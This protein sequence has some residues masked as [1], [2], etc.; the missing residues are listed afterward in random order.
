MSINPSPGHP[1]PAEAV[2]TV[3]AATAAEPGFAIDAK[4]GRYAITVKWR[5]LLGIAPLEARVRPST[6]LISPPYL[7]HISPVSPLYLPCI[8]PIR[9][10]L[11]S[12]H[13]AEP[14]QR[15]GP[16]RGAAPTGAELGGRRQEG[17]RSL[18]RTLTRTLTLTLT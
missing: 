10:A 16:P 15:A 3:T 12:E 5:P 13:G 8:S 9:G 18:T 14:G 7:A 6:E 11:P 1:P 17:G 4:S 2:Q